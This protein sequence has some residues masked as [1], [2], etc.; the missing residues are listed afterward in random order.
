MSSSKEACGVKERGTTPLCFKHLTDI[1]QPFYQFNQFLIYS[2][3]PI[4]SRLKKGTKS[5]EASEP[6]GGRSSEK[7]E[8]RLLDLNPLLDLKNYST[9][10]NTPQTFVGT[11]SKRVGSVFYLSN[12]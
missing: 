8:P 9:S 11:V 7:E 12:Y 4:Y 3:I 5:R 6:V 10:K 1:L 2:T